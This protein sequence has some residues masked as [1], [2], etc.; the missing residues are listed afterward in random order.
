M[1]SPP[2]FVERKTYLQVLGVAG[3]GAALQTCFGR[4][5]LTFSL[6]RR[7]FPFSPARRFNTST[8]REKQSRG[9]KCHACSIWK[10]QL[11]SFQ[12]GGVLLPSS[13]HISSQLLEA[14]LGGGA[15]AQARSDQGPV[16]VRAS[17]HLRPVC[18]H[19]SKGPKQRHANL[20]QISSRSQMFL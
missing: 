18:Q 1:F 3:A 13:P 4:R 5:R 16:G 10:Q 9:F 20:S 11:G 12:A 2:V 14:Q 17:S 7:T 6:L 8:R 15:G 19:M